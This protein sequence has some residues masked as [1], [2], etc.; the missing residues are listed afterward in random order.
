MRTK[1]RV[2]LL[3]AGIVC[4]AFLLAWSEPVSKE[5][6]IQVPGGRVWYRIVG[7]GNATPLLIIHGG[8]GMPSDYLRPLELLSDERPVIFYDQLGCGKS[9]RPK[10]PSLWRED[11]FVEELATVRKALGLNNDVHILAHSWGTMLMM[12]YLK[13]KPRGID[14]LIL[15]GPAINVQRWLADANQYRKQLPAD[16]QATLKKHEDAGTTDSLEYQDAVMVYYQQ[17]LC[18]LQPWPPEMESTMR[19][20][21]MDE[22]LAMW[23]PSEFYA[24]GSLKNFD[25]TT[26]LKKIK[27]PVLFLSGQYDEA[28][29]ETTAY[30]HKLLPGS[31]MVI[32]KGCSHIAMLEQPHEYRRV[33]RE[34]LLKVEGMKRE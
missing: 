29:P 3:L 18:R 30:Y 27:I 34:F 15:A 12:D 4:F 11:R 21:G 22:Y 23:G 10:D 5:G 8:P 20:A 24:T 16:V 2:C 33:V 13:T 14:S 6:F 17:H 32:L 7:S 19:N 31:S 28:T 25:G 9:D 1:L 26:E